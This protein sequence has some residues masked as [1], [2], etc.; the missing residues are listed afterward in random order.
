[1]MIV[2]EVG[3]KALVHAHLCAIVVFHPDWALLCLTLLHLLC[4]DLAVWPAEYLEGCT[5]SETE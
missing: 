3:E 2:A 1:M 4:F 5:A